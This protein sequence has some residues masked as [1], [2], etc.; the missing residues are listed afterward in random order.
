M[1]LSSFCSKIS[2]MSFFPAPEQSTQRAGVV[3]AAAAYLLWGALPLYFL[4]LAPASANEIVAWR[5]IFSLAF[6]VILISATRGWGALRALLR[7]PRINATMALAAIFIFIN[8]Q[9]YVF[10]ALHNE[11]IE[12]SLGYF[13]NPIV[14]VLLGVFLLR[15]RLRPAQWIAVGIS[16][17]AVVVLAVN[18]GALPWIALALA[19]SFGLYGLI[20]KRIGPRVDAL[21]GLTVE[22]A[23]L[24]P[25]AFGQLLLVGAGAG[26]T[27]GTAGAS[28]T[29]LLVSLGVVTGV[30]LLLFA[31]AARRLP[32]IVLG[33]VQYITPLLQFMVGAFLLGE[34]M[35]PARWIG[36][37]LVWLALAI[38]SADVLLAGRRA[39]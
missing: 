17:V 14:T 16:A 30:P 18:Y 5:I 15:E 1:G 21:S 11:V 22:T 29:V 19:F 23:W 7:Q 27:I 32:L 37:G 6:W 25:V 28:H 20:K 12:A 8:W 13:I 24:L 9:V 10:A 4:L 31:A 38:L 3:M 33:L 35:P 26:L 2:L 39:R 36:F 34:A